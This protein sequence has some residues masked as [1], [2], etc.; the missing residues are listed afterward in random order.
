[1]TRYV[2]VYAAGSTPHD[3]R[4]YGMK[5]DESTLSAR[6]GLIFGRGYRVISVREEL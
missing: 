1:M 3:E 4:R 6:I 5:A 2:I